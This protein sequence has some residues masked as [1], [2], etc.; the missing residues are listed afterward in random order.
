VRKQPDFARAVALARQARGPRHGA[1]AL[2]FGVILAAGLHGASVIASLGAAVDVPSARSTREVDAMNLSRIA[3]IGAVSVASGAW[4]GT[5]VPP[6]WMMVADSATQ[7]TDQQGEN[8]WSYWFSQGGGSPEQQMQPSQFIGAQDGFEFIVW[9]PSPTM[10]CPSGVTVCHVLSARELSTG[11]VRNST[12][13]N[14]TACCTPSSGVQ[15]PTLRWSA[16][17]PM[18]VRIEW[19]G[20]YAVTGGG[21]QPITLAVNGQPVL[22]ANEPDFGTQGSTLTLD[23]EVLSSLSMRHERCTPFDFRIRVFTADCNANLVPDAIEIANGSVYDRNHDG[24]PD[25]CQCLADVVENGVVDGADLAAVLAVWGTDGGIYPRAD[26]NAD[27]IVDGSDL[28]VV[29]SSW[30]GCP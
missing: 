9:A 18:P 20:Q 3:A 11:A 27:G 1:P 4:A 24:V 19:Y 7:F 10:G 26:T 5:K 29:L 17:T 28:A 13:G 21:D 22:V 25:S 12:H 6:G 23:A 15:Y 16:P 30:G 2:V 8:G 14:S